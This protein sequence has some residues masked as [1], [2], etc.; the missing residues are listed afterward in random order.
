MKI[1]EF[2]KDVKKITNYYKKLISYTKN[3]RSVGSMNEWI[4]DN[5]Y[6]I[7]EQEKNIKDEYR[8]LETKYIK[9]KR[10]K[11]LY[12]LVYNSLKTNDFQ[13]DITGVFEKLNKYQSE[14]KDYFSFFEINFIYLFI[15]ISLISEL[16]VLCEKF[17]NRLVQKEQVEKSFNLINRSIKE[18]NDIEIED[19]IEISN[20]IIES[21][22]Y[23]EQIHYKL[24][25]LGDYS[26][27]SFVKLNELLQKRG[28]S[29]K[30]LIEQSHND[31]ANDNFI[32]INIFN[33]LKKIVKYEI[34]Y[35][36]KNISFTEQLLVKEKAGIYDEMYDVNKMEYRVQITKNARALKMSEYDYTSSVITLAD[37]NNKHV[38]W[39]L[40]KSPNYKRRA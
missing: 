25:K 19:Y 11:L 1:S 4:I 7:S 38:G 10:K 39:Y 29:F 17:D 40:F 13:I 32:I 31:M 23:I 18:N 37:E 34:E 16:R 33:S 8:F 2:K 12:S 21:P 3:G 6:V 20:D 14:T 30:E 9:G 27:D 5:Y 24:K 36:Y 22:Y 26:E 15:K 28:T 35:L